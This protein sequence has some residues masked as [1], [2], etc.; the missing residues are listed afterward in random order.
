MLLLLAYRVAVA[1]AP[2][3]HLLVRHVSCT[4][5]AAADCLLGATVAYYERVVVTEELVVVYTS[6][7]DTHV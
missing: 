6:I 3:S 1:A 4:A 5:L 7:S 2:P